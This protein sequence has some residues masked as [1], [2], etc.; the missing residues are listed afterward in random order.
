MASDN[1]EQIGS[2]T[3][4]SLAIKSGADF[5]VA[6]DRPY[7]SPEVASFLAEQQAGPSDAT[8]ADAIS[9][10]IDGY[11]RVFGDRLAQVWLFG[12]R[13]TGRY[14]PDSDVDLL[15]VLHEEHDVCRDIDLIVS[16]DMPLLEKMGVYMEGRPTTLRALRGSDD[17][18]HYFVR[19]E[20]RRVDV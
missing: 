17:E 19:K 11:R 20:G 13:A 9:Q 16:V 3:T 14:G 18:F 10:A 5:A 2:A 1:R 15:V 8:V 7:G 12:S 6:R 4:G